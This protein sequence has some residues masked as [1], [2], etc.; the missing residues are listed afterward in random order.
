MLYLCV[1]FCVFV[2]VFVFVVMTN[3]VHEYSSPLGCDAVFIG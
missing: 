3:V 2:F 1:C